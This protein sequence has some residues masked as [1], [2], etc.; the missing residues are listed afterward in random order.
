VHAQ[1]PKEAAY[2]ALGAEPLRSRGSGGTNLNAV[3]EEIR[4]GPASTLY[5]T[6]PAEAEEQFQKRLMSLVQG[7]GLPVLQ[8]MHYGWFLRE[9][10]RLWRTRQG[11]DLAFHLEL[12]IRKWV[13]LGLESRTL[14]FLV[15]EGHTRLKTAKGTGAGHNPIPAAESGLCPKPADEETAKHAKTEPEFTTK[16]PSHKGGDM[17]EIGSEISDRVPSPAKEDD[18]E[19]PE[20]LR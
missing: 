8:V 20:A 5:G 6:S 17:T 9:L 3:L 10:A 2:T 16:A 1:R 15:C 4:T 12:C 13:S 14:Q 18:D 11:R 19:Y 7:A